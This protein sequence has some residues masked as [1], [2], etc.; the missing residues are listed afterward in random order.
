MNNYIGTLQNFQNI[1]QSVEQLLTDEHTS[2]EIKQAAES[3]R[4]SVQPC[5][6]EIQRS[7]TKLKDFIQGSFVDLDRAEDI[8]H[9]KARI[10]S[11]QRAQIWDELGV[12]SGIYFRIRQLENL[13][14]DEATRLAKKSWQEM[15]ERVIDTFYVDSDGKL[16]SLVSLFDRDTL[17]KFIKEQ[18]S[19]QLV[20]YRL[21]IAEGLSFVYR[22]LQAIHIEILYYHVDLLDDESTSTINNKIEKFLNDL[23][24]QF[25]ERGENLFLPGVIFNTI[26][27]LVNKNRFAVERTNV[28]VFQEIVLEIIEKQISSIFTN[29]LNLATQALEQAIA[30]YNDFLER[31]ERYQQE[32]PE[33]RA[34]EK[35]WID[36]QRQQLE[37]VQHGLDAVLHNS[38]D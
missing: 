23:E 25:T 13:S 10:A 31:Q 19:K 33:Q 11:A 21:I 3:L 32:T 30:F 5:F 26:E 7:T 24:S 22:E 38:V 16:R 2:S 29:K 6:N 17:I 34:T 35:A 15:I 37:Q 28:M 27:I 8:W 12:I 20:K 9:S 18:A 36:Q 14:K 1:N 4:Q